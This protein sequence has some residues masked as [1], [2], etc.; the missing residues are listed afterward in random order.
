MFLLFSELEISFCQNKNLISA[1]VLFSNIVVSIS[2]SN[3]LEM[4]L[5]ATQPR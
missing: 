2:R 1:K 3:F 4:K 5:S